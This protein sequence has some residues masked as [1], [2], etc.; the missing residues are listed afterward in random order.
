MRV[1]GS[2]G[3]LCIIGKPSKRKQIPLTTVTFIL[4]RFFPVQSSVRPITVHSSLE[5]I[6][7]GVFRIEVGNNAEQI[8][9]ISLKRGFSSLTA[10]IN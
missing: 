3:T 10:A 1:L 8:Q 2:P 6:K 4:F 9:I 5:V 7:G